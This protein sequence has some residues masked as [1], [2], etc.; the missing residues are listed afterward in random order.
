M[1]KN[2]F[3]IINIS[4]AVLDIADSRKIKADAF[5]S[6]DVL[7]KRYERLCISSLEHEPYGQI[8][9]SKLKSQVKHKMSLRSFDSL[10]GKTKVPE[11]GNDAEQRKSVSGSKTNTACLSGIL[12]AIDVYAEWAYKSKADIFQL[13]LEGNMNSPGDKGRS[14]IKMDQLPV[15]DERLPHESDDHLYD[16]HA[17]RAMIVCTLEYSFSGIYQG[18]PPQ[19]GLPS[20]LDQSMGSVL[21]A[22]AIS[23]HVMRQDGH[24][25]KRPEDKVQA[26]AGL[27]S[28]SAAKDG[29]ANV[30]VVLNSASNI[31]KV[32]KL[33][34]RFPD[35]C[36]IFKSIRSHKDPE[37][38]LHEIMP[39]E[40]IEEKQEVGWD[41]VCKQFMDENPGE[42]K[43]MIAVEI[44]LLPFE[45]LVFDSDLI[46]WGGPYPQSGYLNIRL[47]FHYL[48]YFLFFT[49]NLL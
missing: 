29:R 49:S 13:L 43:K 30:G 40:T 35:F 36:A 1:D 39:G 33:R 22:N 17:G 15:V 26:F 48:S 14:E 10:P 46:H 20:S 37:R 12:R 44:Q 28:F 6:P 5:L 11:L 31:K 8:D 42:F 24:T 3:T 41:F 25:D 16:R 19:A 9:L 45:W 34:R 47:G 32:L 7:H 21:Y 27:T 4:K 23:Q 38:F 2:D 18:L